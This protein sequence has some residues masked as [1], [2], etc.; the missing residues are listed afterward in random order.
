M[1]KIV[2]S[3]ESY[4]IFIGF[5]ECSSHLKEISEY[6]KTINKRQISESINENKNK[7]SNKLHR[8]KEREREV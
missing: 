3:I 8:E 1:L 2:Y 7:M 5:C 4:G 6:R